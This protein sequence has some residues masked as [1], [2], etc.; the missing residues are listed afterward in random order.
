MSE[1]DATG[2]D[3]MTVEQVS[4][5]EARLLRIYRQ[6]PR[7][8]KYNLVRLATGLVR[9]SRSEDYG[10]PRSEIIRRDLA[11]WEREGTLDFVNVNEEK[12]PH[13]AR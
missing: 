4:A 7:R 10:I 9:L 8:L 6:L 12:P 11:R 13:I 1:I 2:S 5:R 3:N